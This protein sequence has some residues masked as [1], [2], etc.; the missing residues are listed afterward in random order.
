M[1]TS[2]LLSKNHSRPPPRCPKKGSGTNV[3]LL[4]VQLKQTSKRNL[5][6]E[7]NQIKKNHPDV[8]C[9]GFMIYP[10]RPVIT[11]NPYRP[12][13]Q[14]E[15]A[16][17]PLTGNLKKTKLILKLYFKL[18]QESNYRLYEQ[19][20]LRKLNAKRSEKYESQAYK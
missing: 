3:T 12:L 14:A 2:I 8:K 9:S 1:V 15:N 17:E 18:N 16:Y 4:I 13:D 6:R 20:I 10:K 7:F 19:R 11:Y 5:T